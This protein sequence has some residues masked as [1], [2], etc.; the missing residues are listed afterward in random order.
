[1]VGLAG[2]VVREARMGWLVSQGTVAS[3]SWWEWPVLGNV[4]IKPIINSNLVV[5]IH[6]TPERASVA[7]V[8]RPID[9]VGG[10]GARRVKSSRDFRCTTYSAGLLPE[11]TV[12]YFPL[13]HPLTR[14]KTLSIR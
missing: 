8:A 14:N 7:T 4:L 2:A 5:I 3:S 12:R 13:D 6:A 10:N 9:T 11:R 1:M